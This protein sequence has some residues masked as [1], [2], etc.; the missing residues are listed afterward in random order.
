MI[1]LLA[2]LEVKI[3][4]FGI[5]ATFV[6]IFKFLSYNPFEFTYFFVPFCYIINNSE[7]INKNLPRNGEEY[8]FE[9]VESSEKKKI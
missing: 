2:H 4:D 5:C 7:A 3:S 6:D 9:K 1:V 8:A